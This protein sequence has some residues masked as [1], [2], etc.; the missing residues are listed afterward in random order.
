MK[1]IMKKS[2]A[3]ILSVVMLF[4][5]TCTNASAAS[6]DISKKVENV[7][8]N[9]LGIV[10]ES[11]VNAINIFLKKN[12]IFIPEDAYEYDNFYEG[13]ASFISSAPADACWSLGQA[14][15]SLV[16]ENYGEYELYLG[17]F[18]SGQ[19][20]FT[21][22]LR[23]ILDDM[24]VRVIALSDGTGRGTSV[25]ATV[26]SIGVSNGDIR[27]IRGMLSDFA[28]ENDINS[29]NI[30]STHSH[31]CIDTQG[32]WTD[33]FGKWPGNIFNSVTGIGEQQQGTDEKY[34]EFF[35]GKVCEAVEDA[36][37][38]MTKGEMTYA[39][40]DIG[41]RY[42]SNKNR[43]SATSLDTQLKRFV[44]TPYDEDIRPT[45]ILNMSAHPDVVGLATKDDPTKGHGLSGD[46]IYYIG[47][48]LNNAGYDFMFFNGA[49]C[50]IYIGRIPVKADT[51][52]DIAANYGREIGKMTLAMTMSKDEITADEYLMSLNFDA[53]KTEETGYVPWYENW[54]PTDEE[55]L[56]P[57]FNI[58]LK[59]VEIKVT[60]PIILAAGKLSLVNHLIKVTNDGKNVITTEIGYIEMG[61]RVKIAML[62][63][64]FCTDLAYGGDSLTADGSFSGDEFTGKTLSEIFGDDIIV[65]GLAN[66]AIG[67]I[68]PDNDY[69]LCIAFD[70]YQESISLGEN[71]ASTIM[72]AFEELQNE[73]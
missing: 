60:N 35:R 14:E 55:E 18:M 61:N 59:K 20:F 13:T 47:E 19:N 29:I 4:S 52:L 15:K 64:E 70:H 67:Y 24:K 73:I 5:V 21:N 6:F 42:F 63:G 37:A 44:F 56:E 8:A 69:C 26:D 3:L 34:M 68:V 33:I 45:I 10:V 25:F 12:D 7:L 1:K 66:D 48:V 40:K 51:R 43:P 38:S 11:L 17:G 41:E 2:V 57:I 22:D 27:Q 9:T 31:S 71:T 65:F 23:E 50:G 58:R 46:Y 54:T 28:K 36:V 72:K 53:D 49:I 39:V 16:P 62:P 30:F 32:L